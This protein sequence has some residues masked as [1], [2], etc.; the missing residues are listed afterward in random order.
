MRF[1]I[2]HLF[3]RCKVH[4][5]RP[6]DEKIMFRLCFQDTDTVTS[7]K[8]YTRKEIVTME[9]S[10]DDFHTSFYIPAIQKLDIHLPHVLIL[11]TNNGVN[12][13]REEFK[14]C[15]EKKHVLR[16][17]NYAERVVASFSH[18]IQSRYYGGN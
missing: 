11:G 15:T 3:S 6:S 9:K 7:V 16:S 12:T 2:Y 10:I 18:Q 14:R 8:L 4:G 5:R 17:R 1:H 13:R